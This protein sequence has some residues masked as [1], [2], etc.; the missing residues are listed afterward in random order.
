MSLTARDHSKIRRHENFTPYGKF[1]LL[2]YRSLMSS[3]TKFFYKINI[4][5]VVYWFYLHVTFRKTVI[6][7]GGHKG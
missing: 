4:I 3:F 2:C 7:H 1:S 5:F 6:F